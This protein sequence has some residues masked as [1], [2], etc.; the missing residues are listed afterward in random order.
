[1]N[2]ES[3]FVEKGDWLRSEVNKRRCEDRENNQDAKYVY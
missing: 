1:M 2:M 3:R